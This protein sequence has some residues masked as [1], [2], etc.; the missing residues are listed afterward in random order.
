MIRTMFA[1]VL[2][3]AWGAPPALAADYPDRPVKLVVPYA[4]GG[5]PDVLTR[6]MA[7]KM[8]DTLGQRIVIDNRVGGGGMLAATSVAGEPPVG[9]TVMIGASSHVTQKLIQPSLPFD[10]LKNFVA[11]GKAATGATV[12]VV[13]AKSPYRSVAE[14]VA[15]A[16]KNPGKL[17][18]GSGGLGS[19]AHLAGAA[20]MTV[21]ALDTVHVPYRGSV[22]IVPSILGG[23]TQ[24]GFPIASTAIPHVESGKVRALAVTSAARLPQLPG[25][26]TLRESLGNNDDAVVEAWFGLWAPAGTPEATVRKLFDAMNKALADPEVVATMEKLGSPP[27]TSASPDAFRR[28]MEAETVKYRRIVAASK[29]SVD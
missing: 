13:D 5:G 6:V 16:R 2:L 27:A 11:I 3:A 25:V 17:N 4:A 8:S 21:A 15:D 12:L 9:Y 18:Y 29:I 10:P 14:L 26:P 19:A 28:F 24:F 7:A 1:L 20:F 23:S 22:E